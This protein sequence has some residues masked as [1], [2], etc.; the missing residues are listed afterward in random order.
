M[1]TAGEASPQLTQAVPAQPAT[2]SAEQQLVELQPLVDERKKAE[3]AQAV[4]RA[5]VDN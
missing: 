3:N 2:G 1:A 4:T 5:R